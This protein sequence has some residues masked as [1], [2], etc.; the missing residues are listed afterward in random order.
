MSVTTKTT[1]KHG[2]AITEF[3][4]N[5]EF[6]YYVRELERRGLKQHYDYNIYRSENNQPVVEVYRFSL[7]SKLNT[8]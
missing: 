6:E 3:D 7:D 4:I 5:I 1:I 8:K 2:I